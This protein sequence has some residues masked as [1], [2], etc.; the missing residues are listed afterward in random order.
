M[1]TFDEEKQKKQIDDF[2]KHEEEE[3]AKMLSQKYGM[4]YIDLSISP[5][6]SDAL[7]IITEEEC[8]ASHVALFNVANKKVSLA[9]VAPENPA[10]QETVNRVQERGYIV[11]PYMVSQNSLDKVWARYKDLSFSLEATGGALDISSDE[12]NDILKNVSNINDIKK[13]VQETLA[14]KKTH[15]IS[16][17]LEIILAGALATK[18]SDIHLEPEE[19]FVR[20]RYRLDGVLVEIMQFDSETYELLVSRLKLLSGMKINL[21]GIAQ[22]GRFSIRLQDSEIQIRVSVLPGAYSDS[23][24][25]RVLNPKSINVALEDMGIDPRLFKI[26]EHEISKPN[27]IILT[28]GPTGSGKTTTLYSFLKRIYTPDIKIITIENPVEYHLSGIVQTQVDARKQD[29]A[30]SGS[31]SDGYTF[32]EGLRA[33]LRQDPD[34]IM[35]GE[36]RD[37]ETATTAINA[38][39]TGHLVFS[40]LHTNNAAGTFPRLLDLGINPK[41]ITSAVNISMAQR[42]VRKLCLECKEKKTLEG[43]DKTIIDAVVAG[44]K[45]K[46]YLEG[47]A[48]DS[49]WTSKGCTACNNTGYKG[50]VGIFE[51]ILADENVEKAIMNNPSEREIRKAAEPQNILSLRQDGV[52]KILKGI[53]SMDELR[54][55]VDME[56]A[57]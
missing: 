20:L 43:A 55:V 49:I 2:R 36:I 57:E 40:T 7:R 45:D 46:T 29:M 10:T 38:A 9:M 39:L 27:G 23:F 50:R 5:V 4:E 42:L 12:I 33:V 26:L 54:R 30:S 14:L 11:I 17:I 22:D 35:V 3:L 56:S 34:V 8:R 25:M 53:T 24:V 19:T 31:G 18:S 32:A 13:L 44:I 1:V 47:V 48:T 41:V 52:I 16:K 51:A 6:S 28:T 15:R 21:R 37:N